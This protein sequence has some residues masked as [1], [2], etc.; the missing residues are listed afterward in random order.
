MDFGSIIMLHNQ[1]IILDNLAVWAWVS[2][3]DIALHCKQEVSSV[4][5]DPSL[6]GVREKKKFSTLWGQVSL[7]TPHKEWKDL[8]DD[9][10]VYRRGD[11]IP[12]CLKCWLSGR[13]IVIVSTRCWHIWHSFICE[14]TGFPTPLG[15]GESGAWRSG[16]GFG[17]WLLCLLALKL[18]K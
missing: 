8:G 9:M 14:L 10:L 5:P 3:R 16:R 4:Y 17:R 15:M 7:S 12:C 18:P 13:V 2:N 1:I 6:T 11:L